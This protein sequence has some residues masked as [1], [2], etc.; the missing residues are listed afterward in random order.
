MGSIERPITIGGEYQLAGPLIAR[1][2]AP[3]ETTHDLEPLRVDVQEH[4]LAHRQAS[5][6]R[7]KALD[8]LRGVRAAATDDGDFYPHV[9]A[10][11][12]KIDLNG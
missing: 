8:E 1:E 4:E 7:E 11:Y 2:D 5:S 10:W 3:R 6:A 12:A 9:G